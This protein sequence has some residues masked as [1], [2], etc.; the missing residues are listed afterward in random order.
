MDY[1][2]NMVMETDR[3]IIGKIPDKY[4][5]NFSI[6]DKTLTID[7]EFIEDHIYDTKIKYWVINLRD[8]FNWI[9]KYKTK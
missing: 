9:I 5:Y 2:N 1:L 7:T 6:K 3:H 4:I 8:K